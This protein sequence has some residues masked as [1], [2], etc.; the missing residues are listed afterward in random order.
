MSMN[1]DRC[2]KPLGMRY[3][4]LRKRLLGHD[5]GCAEIEAKEIRQDPAASPRDRHRAQEAI[6]IGAF[7]RALHGS[8][9]ALALVLLLVAG[10]C[11]R[12]RWDGDASSCPGV[13]EAGTC[14]VTSYGP[15]PAMAQ[16]TAARVEAEAIW[17]P[18]ILRGWLVEIAAT[19]QGCAASPVACAFPDSMSI[20]IKSTLDP[21]FVG[22]VIHE[23]GHTGKD[24]DSHH[25]DSRW[26]TADAAM[27]TFILQCQKEN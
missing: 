24:P 9:T 22:F 21:C 5:C 2:N 18:G 26:G 13:V 3:V 7:W 14:Y 12:P 27:F 16:I 6:M 4:S 15:A 8:I 17:G 20:V 23:A 11:D 25:L 1:C 19:M 10:G